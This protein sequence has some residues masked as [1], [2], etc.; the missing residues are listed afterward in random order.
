MPPPDVGDELVRIGESQMLKIMIRYGDGEP[1]AAGVG[2]QPT[3]QR[4]TPQHPAHLEPQVKMRP[5]LPM[6]VQNKP[7]RLELFGLFAR[8]I[9]LVR[10]HVECLHL[11][12]LVA[13]CWWL[14]VHLIGRWWL[15]VLLNGRR[16][17]GALGVGR[18]W[19]GVAAAVLTSFD[20]EFSL[21]RAVF[22][23]GG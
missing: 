23:G 18:W 7:R 5:R 21:G 3:W 10:F 2:R 19:F 13:E 15:G 22:P 17:L 14:G 4:P 6:I 9:P 16:E 1:I 8:Y 12:V 11:G 20:A